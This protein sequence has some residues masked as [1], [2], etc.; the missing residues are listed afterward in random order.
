MKHSNLTYFPKTEPF[1]LYFIPDANQPSRG[2]INM[3]DQLK[4]VHQ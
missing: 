1:F 2:V 3:N 4:V